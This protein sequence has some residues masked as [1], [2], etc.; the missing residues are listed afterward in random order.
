MIIGKHFRIHLMQRLFELG[1]VQSH[2]S[3]LPGF[4][5]ADLEVGSMGLAGGFVRSPVGSNEDRRK[6]FQPPARISIHAEP[7]RVFITMTAA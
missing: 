4:W 6:A 2:G 7:D 5:R 1:R 3:L